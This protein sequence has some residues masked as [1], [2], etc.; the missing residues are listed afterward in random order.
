MATK[1]YYRSLGV[2]PLASQ[3]EIHKSYRALAKK[4]HP[5]I[6]KEKLLADEKMKEI[7]E[8]YNK[9]KDHASRKEYD[10]RPHFK[11]R[12]FKR[13][14]LN[15]KK[16]GFLESLF[17]KKDDPKKRDGKSG[18][19]PIEESFYMGITYVQMRKPD[20]LAL[21]IQEFES[22][23]RSDP[24]IPDAH[25]NLGLCHYL[26][27]DFEKSIMAFKK[28][29]AVNPKDEQAKTMSGMLYEDQ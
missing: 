21:A 4:Y 24:K 27:G 28:V 16:Q 11:F 1:D 20:S 14:T 26:L 17:K 9:L 6:C 23:I 15:V 22:I 25:Y 3:E 2:S 12:E 5:D 10:T 18:K 13:S 8:A 29:L 7:T 19:N